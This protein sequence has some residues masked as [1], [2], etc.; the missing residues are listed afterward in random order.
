MAKSAVLRVRVTFEEK[1]AIR[2]DAK[3]WRMTISEFVRAKLRPAPNP[4]IGA[5]V[6]AAWEKAIKRHGA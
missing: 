2:R 1:R 5:T 6:A 3:R 4:N